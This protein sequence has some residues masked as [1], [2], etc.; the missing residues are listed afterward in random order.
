[1][2]AAGL[3]GPGY[4]GADGRSTRCAVALRYLERLARRQVEMRRLGEVCIERHET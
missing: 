3:P 4:R 2:E 1:M